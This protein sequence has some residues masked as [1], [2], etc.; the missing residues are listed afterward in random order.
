M[1]QQAFRRVLKQAVYKLC[2]N[3]PSCDLLPQLLVKIIQASCGDVDI[4]TY[5]RII[6]T[7]LCV[8][9]CV[10]VPVFTLLFHL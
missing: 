3:E 6:P 2:I 1:Q 5:F 10:C 9:V 4:C 8:C 7:T